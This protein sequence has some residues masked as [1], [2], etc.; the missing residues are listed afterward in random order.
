[1]YLNMM[2][3]PENLTVKTKKLMVIVLVCLL[4]V[5]IVI[6]LTKLFRPMPPVYAPVGF[7]TDKLEELADFLPKYYEE[8]SASGEEFNPVM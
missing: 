1:M 6:F 5:P 8:I 4:T 7:A 2:R 3:L